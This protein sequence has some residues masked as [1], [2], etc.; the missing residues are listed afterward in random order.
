[1]EA[2]MT[3]KSLLAYRGTAGLYFILGLALLFADTT[4]AAAVFFLLGICLMVRTHAQV[5]YLAQNRPI[6]V[7]VPFIAV[8]LVS[9]TIMVFNL[10]LP[11]INL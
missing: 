4:V 10:V 5:D 11:L 8:L 1:M 2:L 6:L 3:E 7:W 9:L